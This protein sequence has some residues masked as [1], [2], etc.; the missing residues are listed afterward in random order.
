MWS[1]TLAAKMNK[2]WMM[3]KM[4]SRQGLNFEE[5]CHEHFKGL[6]RRL[7]EEEEKE[8]DPEK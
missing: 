6:R 8:E 3:K 7:C 5:L 1:S 4:E 2:K